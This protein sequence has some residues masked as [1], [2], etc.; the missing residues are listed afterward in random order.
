VGLFLFDGPEDADR[1]GES[2]NMLCFCN[3]P[4][5]S[6]PCGTGGGFSVLDPA[7]VMARE[8]EPGPSGKQP[9]PLACTIPSG[10]WQVNEATDALR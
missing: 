10:C 6:F 5:T 8:G 9:E 3:F 7:G 4:D 1:D 2:S